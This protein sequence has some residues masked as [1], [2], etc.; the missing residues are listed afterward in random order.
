SHPA[1]RAAA[2]FVAGGSKDPD[3]RQRVRRLLED[4]D[5]KVRLRAAEGLIAGKDK[6]AVPTVISL[7]GETSPALNGKAEKLLFQIDGESTAGIC[8]ADGNISA[9]HQYRDLWLA[10][11]QKKGDTIDWPPAEPEQPTPNFPILIEMDSSK[12]WELGA[13]GRAN[14]EIR[15]IQGAM[16]A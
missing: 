12:V 6:V 15:N 10:W 3:L 7:L 8:L 1:R 11:W 4:S 5:S 13:G 9:R 14:W 2:A 16:D